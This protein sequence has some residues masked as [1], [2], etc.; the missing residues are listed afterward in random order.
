M[1]EGSQEC[2]KAA[3]LEGQRLVQ[4]GSQLPPQKGGEFPPSKTCSDFQEPCTDP[5]S[6]GWGGERSLAR[7]RGIS[8]PK[9]KAG[10]SFPRPLLP[11]R[12][13]G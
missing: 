6:L 1:G 12:D 10:G 9:P 7:T 3:M 13:L 4:D 8:V 11:G 2:L 5:S